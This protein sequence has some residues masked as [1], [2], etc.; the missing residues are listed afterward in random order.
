MI[1]LVQAD[2]NTTTLTYNSYLN[3]P[4]DATDHA[5][6]GSGSAAIVSKYNL[7]YKEGWQGHPDGIQTCGGNFTGII[8]SYNMYY[9]S[10]SGG[11]IAGVQP[12]HI[13]AQCTSAISNSTISYNTLALLGACN[14]GSNYPTGCSVNYGIACKLDS[15]SNSNSGFASYGNY[16]DWTGA[17]AAESNGYACTGTTWGSP[18]AN[19]DMSTGGVL[20]TTP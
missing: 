20:T 10:T 14:A 1:N 19:I 2:G 12:F 17:I 9:T 13:E 4:Q 11:T 15:G 7:F 5:G 6:P 18:V 16:I 8:V 3:T